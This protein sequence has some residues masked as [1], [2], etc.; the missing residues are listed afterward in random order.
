MQD[1]AEVKEEK[2]EKSKTTAKK[3]GGKKQAKGKAA[4]IKTS[5]PQNRMDD[6]QASTSRHK[7]ELFPFEKL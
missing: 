1:K 2:S 3:G 5:W 6:S 4:D 7:T